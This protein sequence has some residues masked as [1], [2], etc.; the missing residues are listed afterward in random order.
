M[1]TIHA[2]LKVKRGRT[3]AVEIPTDEEIERIAMR[4]HKSGQPYL[5]TILG[6]EV[7]YKPLKPNSFSTV[8]VDAFKDKQ[9]TTSAPRKFAS[10]AE[11][12]F[13]YKA[14]WRVVLSWKDGDDKPPTK[15]TYGEDKL[16][17]SPKQEPGKLF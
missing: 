12:T 4:M 16:I 5:E 7:F 10:P 9:G 2:Q 3:V 13:G 6:W 1:N 14:P 15:F 8:S 11:F 17:L